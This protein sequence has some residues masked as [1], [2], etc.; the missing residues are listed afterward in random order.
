MS[1]DQFEF[2]QLAQRRELTTSTRALARALIALAAAAMP[3]ACDGGPRT[4]DAQARPSALSAEVSVRFDASPGKPATVQVLAFRATVAGSERTD[5]LGI[6]DPL[7]A[8]APEQGCALRDVDLATSALL[9]RGGSIE[10]QEMTGIGV[11]LGSGEPLL[12]PF[13]RLYPDVATVVGGVVAESGP[14]PLGALPEHVSLYTADSELPVADL[15]VPS[16]PRLTAVNGAAVTAGLRI[17]AQEALTVGVSGAGGGLVELRPF[18]ATVAIACA[19]PTTASGDAIV[20]IAPGLLAHVLGARLGAGTAPLAASLD[21]ARRSRL[22][23]SLGAPT[24]R[25]SVEVRA[26][27]TVELRP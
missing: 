21:V 27:T 18:G 5:V 2:V 8:A 1:S 12:R 3:A 22:R 11:G 25:I 20:V 23:Q 15:A 4:P 7:A 9:A 10:L 6:V 24:A 14:Q 26:G 17:N 19:V 16:A 13:P